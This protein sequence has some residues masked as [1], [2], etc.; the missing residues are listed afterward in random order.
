MTFSMGEIEI[1]VAG[2]VSKIAAIAIHKH[3]RGQFLW[4]GRPEDC[5]Y[6]YPN[7]AM[8]TPFKTNEG[9]P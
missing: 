7:A 8:P 3:Q 9:K 6:C 2:Q 1:T 5:P 4:E